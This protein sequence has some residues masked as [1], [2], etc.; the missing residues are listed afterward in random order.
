MHDTG[1]FTSSGDTSS[2]SSTSH[3]SDTS[4]H[5]GHTSNMSPSSPGTPLNQNYYPT[6]NPA[7][8]GGNTGFSSSNGASV[9]RMILIAVSILL[10]IVVSLIVFLSFA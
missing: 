8:Y 1:G 9:G 7:S 3:T 10:P 5:T 6:L 4:W 2:H